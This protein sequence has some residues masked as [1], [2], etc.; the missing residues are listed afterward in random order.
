MS[1]DPREYPLSLDHFEKQDIFSVATA[2]L[3]TIKDIPK[4]KT[5]SELFYILD[6]D[7]F[8]KLIKYFGGMEIRIPSSKEVASL[9]RVLLLY[10]YYDVDKMDWQSAMRKAG[11]SPEEGQRAR[12]LLLRF[13]EL[14]MSMR[15]G[16]NYV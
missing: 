9:L 12:V 15:T 5:V 6:Y 10:Q 13:K 11:F 4:Y 2:L 7:S 3:Y 8:L 14:L 16:R 1:D